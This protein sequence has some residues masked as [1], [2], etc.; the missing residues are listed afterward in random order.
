MPHFIIKLDTKLGPR[1]LEWSTIVD[2][3]VT[4]G[5]T[6]DEFQTYW[7]KEYGESRNDSL[8]TRLRDVESKGTDCRSDQSVDETIKYNRAGADE[9][10]LTKAQIIDYYCV[11]RGKGERPRGTNNGWDV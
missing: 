4:Y 7:R 8:A 3:P 6:L 1:Y 9:T 10:R 2:A 11:R 5:V